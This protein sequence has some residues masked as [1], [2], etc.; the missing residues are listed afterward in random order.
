MQLKASP[1]QIISQEVVDVSVHTHPA[2]ED[3]ES[4]G[5]GKLDVERNLFP[6]ED[7]PRRFA[8]A[9]KIDFGEA[10][11]STPPPYS[12]SIS[13]YGI[14]IVHED[15]PNDPERLIRITGASMLYGVGREMISQITARSPNGIL[16][17]PSISFY[18]DA[19]KPKPAKKKRDRK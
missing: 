17:L 16:T 7:N 4:F 19:P 6:F 12:G 13:L 3:Q 1:I 11:N 5:R 14:Y 9:L 2:T 18:E 8:V 10:D 15:F